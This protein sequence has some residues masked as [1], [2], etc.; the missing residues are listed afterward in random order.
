MRNLI[1]DDYLEEQKKYRKIH[2]PHTIL[3]MQVGGFFEM[4]ALDE[5]NLDTL[6]DVATICNLQIS[7]KNNKKELSRSNP[8]MAG[9]PLAAIEKYVTILINN[10]Y[11]VVVIEQV[12]PS[13]DPER[14]VTNI[15]CPRT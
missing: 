4:Y 3:L 2:G 14:K 7:K 10:N 1:Y 8:Y 11:T 15:F 13:P 5:Y 9:F 12:T 6:Q